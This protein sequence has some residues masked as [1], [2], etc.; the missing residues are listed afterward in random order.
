[1]VFNRKTQNLIAEFRGLPTDDSHSID[2]GVKR[3]DSLVT[4]LTK[5]YKLHQVRPEE[6]VVRHWSDIMGEHA[7]R[8]QPVKIVRGYQLVISI[9][10]PVVKR[11]VIF[12]RRSILKRLRDLPGLSNIRDIHVLS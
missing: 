5:Q 10:N 4:V 1:M 3:M 11:E 9:P 7:N 2:R 8:S 6:M 12:Q